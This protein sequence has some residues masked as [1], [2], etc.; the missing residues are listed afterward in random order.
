MG[1]LHPKAC[2]ELV[3]VGLGLVTAQ[4][5]SEGE[6]ES[7]ERGQGLEGRETVRTNSPPGCGDGSRR[8]GDRKM[9]KGT[10]ETELA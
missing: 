9:R 6:D 10:K 8:Q 4:D 2:C 1:A 5:N 7:R 3:G